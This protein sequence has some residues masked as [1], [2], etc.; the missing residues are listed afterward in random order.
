MI[1]IIL[2]FGRLNDSPRKGKIDASSL[3]DDSEAEISRDELAVVLVETI[4]NE[5][6]YHKTF[7]VSSGETPI[8]AAI[9]SN[10]EGKT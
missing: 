3:L 1:F 6:T 4:E 5:S 7:E 9:A 8:L 10:K 2:R